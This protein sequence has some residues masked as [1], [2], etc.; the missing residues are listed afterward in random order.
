VKRLRNWLYHLFF[1]RIKRECLQA[2][3]EKTAVLE[4]Q[5]GEQATWRGA[6]VSDVEQR[7]AIDRELRDA[8]VKDL[9]SEVNKL[10]EQLNERESALPSNR[11]VARTFS[12]FRA[13]AE[14]R[15]QE[16]R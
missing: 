16:T 15:P 7:L 13:A 10:R 9:I 6:I 2:I 12:E 3:I 4:R 5:I 8:V 1:G 11:R 14:G